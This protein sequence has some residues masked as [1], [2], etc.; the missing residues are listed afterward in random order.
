[1]WIEI[2]NLILV[3]VAS[4]CSASEA[5]NHAEDIQLKDRTDLANE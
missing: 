1:M 4:E 2:D 3:F 5:A